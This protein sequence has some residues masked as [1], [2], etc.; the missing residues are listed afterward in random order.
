MGRRSLE[1]NSATMSRA[2]SRRLLTRRF[3][4]YKRIRM[5][6]LRTSKLKRR[7]WKILFSRLLLNYIKDKEVLHQLVKRKRMKISRTSCSC[8]KFCE[9]F[10]KPCERV[11]VIADS[12][13]F[14]KGYVS[15]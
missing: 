4:G 10:F 3:L 15:N 14:L 7:K 11:I 13:Q 2:K 5:P 6:L 8:D 1:E 12:E 9:A